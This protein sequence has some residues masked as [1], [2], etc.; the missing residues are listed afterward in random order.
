MWVR[1][2]GYQW[3]RGGVGVMPCGSSRDAGST[4]VLLLG[5]VGWWVGGMMIY[6]PSHRRGVCVDSG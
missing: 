4:R 6:C 1:S 2:G 3:F 5:V